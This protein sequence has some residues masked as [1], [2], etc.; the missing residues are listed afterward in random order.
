MKNFHD[1]PDLP[2][3]AFRR[4]PGGSIKPQGGGKGSTPKQPDYIGAAQATAQGNLDLAKYSTQANRANQ[5][6]PYGSL[7]W[8]NNRAFDQAGYDAAL[9]AYR[10]GQS[11]QGAGG[12]WLESPGSYG[13]AGNDGPASIRE[14]VPNGSGSGSGGLSAPNIND[15]Y[16]GG[17]NW[18]QTVTLSPE[19]QAIYDQQMKLSQGLFGAQDAALGR[20]NQMMGSGFDMSKLPSAGTALDINGLPTA[21]SAYDPNQATNTATEA[22]LSRVNPELDRQYESLRNQLAN[23]GITQGSAAWNNAMGSFGQQ[24]NDAVTQAGLQGINLGMQQQGQTYNQ[25]TQNRALAAA[26]QGQ[27]FGQAN[28]ARGNALQEQAY[29][30]N[31]PLNELNALRSGSQVQMPQF[32]SYAQQATTGGADILGATQAGYQSALG[33]ANAQNAAAQQAGSGLGGLAGAGLGYFLGGPMG[34]M[35]GSGVGGALGGLFSDR[36]LK[37]NIKRIGSAGAL[38]VY[39]YEYIWGGPRQIGFMADEVAKVAPQAV[40]DF[41]GLKVV[42]YEAI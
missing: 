7:T 37:K 14:W 28:T 13:Y 10:Q 42:D 36:R 39:S 3:M 30:R 1:I 20:V 31:L 34:G 27:Q 16:S 35:L 22:I 40:K 26:L 41:G 6:T 17:D 5:V 29:L 38:G 24:R 25:M 11:G 15:F 33:A 19:M 8:T 21:G 4:G 2:E 12:Q 18:T 32:G 23:Q 9:A